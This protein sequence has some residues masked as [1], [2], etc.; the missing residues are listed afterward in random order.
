[1]TTL[2]GNQDSTREQKTIVPRFFLLAVVVTV[3]L[4]IVFFTKKHTSEAPFSIDLIEIGGAT[5]GTTYSVKLTRLP[6]G[7][8]RDALKGKMDTILER[9]NALMSTYDPNSE[10]SRFNRQE[11]FDWFPIS[12]ETAEVIGEALAVSKETN[13]AFDITVGPLIDAWGFGGKNPRSPHAEP[14]PPTEAKISA[15]RQKVG[16]RFLELRDDPPGI[17]RQR[18]GLEIDVSA[19]A[20][21]YAV[22]R[23]AELVE[24]H[25]LQ[26]YM[27]E[28]GGEVRTR[29]RKSAESVFQIGIESP[30]RE[31]RRVHTIVRLNDQAMATSGDYRNYYVAN[32][33]AYS[34]IVDP[35]TGRP[36]EHTLASATV[37]S[38]KCI[39][40]DALATALVVLGPEE[41]YNRAL[42][43]DWPILLLVRAKVGD[44][45]QVTET[46]AE[47]SGMPEIVEKTSPGFDRL[48]VKPRKVP[49][50][51]E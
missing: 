31:G 43:R 49:D 39:Y 48:R 22:D 42:E 35:R 38:D 51:T 50:Q 37:I 28:V 7:M 4:L 10:I 13:G 1:M 16:F 32:G 11:S 33:K 12:A 45:L 23:L 17:R 27:V 3:A 41:G 24:E 30:T 18:A 36:V 5:M 15:A 8:T 9:I 40:A 21:G 6:E 20:K 2:A 47:V 25:E 14:A 44:G 29:G 19:I 34:H 46:K 26:N